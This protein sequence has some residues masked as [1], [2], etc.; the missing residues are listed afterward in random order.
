M[1]KKLYIAMVGLPARGK[2]FMAER[3]REGL[4][5]DGLKVGVF[6]NGDLRRA[7]LGAASAL[8]EFYDPANREGRR[9]REDIARA[10]MFEAREFLAEGGNVAILDATNGSRARREFLERELGDA[11]L[12]FIECHNNDEDLLSLSIKRKARLPEFAGMT[13]G[14]AERAFRQRIAYYE[15]ISAPLAAGVEKRFARVDTFR[16]QILEERGGGELPFYLQI[17]D[18]MIADWIRNMYLARHC[19][20]EYN[21]RARI[22]GDSPLTARGMTQARALAAHFGGA[23]IPYVFTS[24]RLRSS[25]TAAPV[26]EYHPDSTLVALPEF[27]EIDAGICEGMTYAEIKQKMPKEYAARSRDKYGYVYPGGEG[28]VSLKERVQRGFRKAMFL[29]GAA[30]GVLIIGHQAINR[31]ILSLFMYR[32]NDSVPYI[33]VPQDEYFHI[34]AT[35]RTKLLEV[36]RFTS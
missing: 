35:H 19:E 2:S 13:R 22:G 20:S 21:V 14:E 10:N 36:V 26:L 27:D 18:I 31:V 9:Q 8:P 23:E 1:N 12:L 24:T 15:Q 7:E 32:R 5:A 3:L 29:S 30:P 4:S 17:R 33:Y 6:N 25:M 16:N 28:Y 34:V 11:P